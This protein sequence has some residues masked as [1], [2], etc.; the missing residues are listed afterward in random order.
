MECNVYLL[1]P[2][3]GSLC[4]ILTSLVHHTRLIRLLDC[5]NLVKQT[6]LTTVQLETTIN[7]FISNKLN[8]VKSMLATV[9]NRLENQFVMQCVYFFLFR[10]PSFL[11]FLPADV[12]RV[13]FLEAYG[14]RYI[15]TYYKKGKKWRDNFQNFLFREW[16]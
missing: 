5:T 4:L 3:G 13:Q 9:V 15:Y 16:A 7:P 2:A 12:K 14:N 6:L 10:Y 8:T 1:S 11:K